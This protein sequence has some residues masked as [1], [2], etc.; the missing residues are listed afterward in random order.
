ME[1]QAA[2]EGSMQIP[3][4]KSEE[5]AIRLCEGCPGGQEL[6]YAVQDRSP[7]SGALRGS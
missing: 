3:V 4:R 7:W 6:A 2:Q 5:V 1:Q